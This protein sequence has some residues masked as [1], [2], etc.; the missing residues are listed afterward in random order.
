MKKAHFIGICGAGMSAVAKLLKDAGW[1][2]T[3]SDEGFYPPASDYLESQNIPCTPE[4]KPDNIKDDLNLIVIGKHA[5]LVPEENQEVAQAFTSGITVRSFPEVLQDIVKDRDNLVVAGS[6]GKSTCAYILTWILKEAGKDPG[7]F[8]GAYSTNFPDSSNL[9]TGPQFVLEGDEYPSANWDQTSKFLYYSPKSLLLTSGEHDHVNVFPTLSSYLKPF[10]DLVA[11]VPETGTITACL[12]GENIADLIKPAKARVI[13]YSLTSCEADWWAENIHWEAGTGHFTLIKKGEKVFDANTVLLGEHNISNLV[14]VSAL[15]LENQLV[16]P[17]ELVSA[18]SRFKGLRRRLELKTISTSIP[19]YEDF[20]SSRAKALAGIK[21]VRNQYPDWRLIVVFEPH[22][23][24]FRNREALNWYDDLFALA[25]LI[26]IY[27]PPTHG[28]KTHDQLSLAEIVERVRQSGKEVY[29]FHAK[30]ELV[31]KF[32]SLLKAN[33][34]VIL[35]ETSGNL[36]GAIPYLT[37][38]LQD[39][40]KV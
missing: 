10:Q 2:V 29:P 23:F 13:T 40:F 20:G 21:A 4:Y 3:G 16:K 5:K 22:T 9:G 8:I 6:F 19:L 15:L 35:I 39:S 28:A 26:Y 32:D 38:Y 33:R 36:G 34:D 17:E 37:D 1:E 11:S 27:D 7:Y 31:N 24:S 14:G 25:D 18:L 30:E 12:D